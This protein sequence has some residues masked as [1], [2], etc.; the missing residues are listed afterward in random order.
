V[1]DDKLKRFEML[2][3]PDWLARVDQWRA[4][5]PGIPSRAEAIRRLVLQA[6][7]GE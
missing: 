1:A 5:Q 4:R 2:A 3:P 6:L 7:E